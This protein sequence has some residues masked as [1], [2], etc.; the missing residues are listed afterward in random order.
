MERRSQCANPGRLDQRV[1]RVVLDTSALLF[2][3]LKPDALP[4]SAQRVINKAE[5]HGLVVSAISLWEI[6][7][8]AQRGTLSLGVS[9][10]DYARRLQRVEALTLLPVDASIWLAVLALPWEHRD[11]ADRVIVA[12][13]QLQGMSLVSSDETIAAFYPKT[14]W[15]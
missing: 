13:A 2:W 5:S 7:L 6:G 1:S 8:K 12:T 4:R 9:F 3:T 10:E 14:V 11:P 15:A